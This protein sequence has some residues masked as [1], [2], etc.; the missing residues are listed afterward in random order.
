MNRLFARAGFILLVIA[1]NVSLARAQFANPDIKSGKIVLHKVL[2]LPPTATVTKSGMKGNETL[3]PESQTVEAA[4]PGIIAEAMQQKG[5]TVLDNIFSPEALEKNPDLKTEVADLQNRFDELRKHMNEKPKDVRNGRFTMGDEVANFNP[6]A[7]ADALVFVRAW[8]VVNTGGK[9]VLGAIAGVNETD[10][11]VVNIA[12]VDSQSGAV[13]Y[14]ALSAT[15]G[16]YLEHPERMTK[17]I[18][19]SFRDWKVGT[20]K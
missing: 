11:I 8:G 9:K 15:G 6:G 14:Y 2:I 3:I 5:C 12:L 10:Y 4:L 17:P 18:E 1:C 19:S 20:G 7:V 13:L 16:S